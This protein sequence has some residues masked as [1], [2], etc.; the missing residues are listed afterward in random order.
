MDNEIQKTLEKRERL[1]VQY[2]E[3]ENQVRHKVEEEEAQRYGLKISSLQAKLREVEE[4]R[5]KLIRRN[6]DLLYEI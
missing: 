3:D 5:E 4:T 2:I 1:R 6:Q